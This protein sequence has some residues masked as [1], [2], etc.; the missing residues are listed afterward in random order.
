MADGADP[1]SYQWKKG[2]VDI[3]GATGSSLTLANLQLS[4]A[5]NYSLR[6]TNAYG[7]T[8]SSDA[9]LTVQA[10]PAPDLTTELIGY[11]TFDETNGLAAADSSGRGNNATLFGSFPVDNSEWVPGK[12]GGAL[13]F[14][15]GVTDNNVGTD[16]PVTLDNGNQFTFS[17]WA[18]RDPGATGTMPRFITPNGSQSWVLWQ[19]GR[20]VGFATPAI[21]TEPSSNAWHIIGCP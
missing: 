2:G 19:P 5:G 16:N 1:L 8:N 11:W 10:L 9:V 13:R 6:V 12:I 18:R 4:D 20:G 17:F 3:A 14:N 21:S 7:T 15:N